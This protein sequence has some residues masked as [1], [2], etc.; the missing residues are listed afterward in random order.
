MCR[1]E[2]IRADLA[3]LSGR[4]VAG[5]HGL[6]LAAP[7]AGTGLA[8][9]PAGAAGA[10]AASAHR[11]PHGAVGANL[12]GHVEVALSGIGHAAV[13]DANRVAVGA[14]ART[15]V[16]NN[17]NAPGP[18]EVSSAG[19]GSGSHR[20]WGGNGTK[21]NK[22]ATR[23]LSTHHQTLG[24]LLAVGC[25]SRFVG[26]GEPAATYV[27]ASRCRKFPQDDLLFAQARACAS[28]VYRAG[29]RIQDSGKVSSTSAA[30]RATV[31]G[32]PAISPKKPAIVGASALGASVPV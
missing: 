13:G 26:T 21:R 14:V 9:Q 3:A 17:Q 27:Y 18:I 22:D 19:S 31:T 32:T 15:L 5:A 24:R 30:I 12:A 7:G 2:A 28:Y 6:T 10:L 20:H 4:P 11:H 16:G 25:H 29:R 23:G 1:V 8:K